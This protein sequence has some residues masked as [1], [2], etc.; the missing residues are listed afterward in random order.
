ND[1]LKGFRRY[2]VLGQPPAVESEAGGEYRAG[3]VSADV[4]APSVPTELPNM[5]IKP[6]ESILRVIGL[7]RIME[8]LARQ[9]I[10]GDRRDDPVSC[11]RS[12]DEAVLRS[13]ALLE[14]AT[15]QEQEDW[16]AGVHL[17]R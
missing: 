15:V 14:A 11:E 6:D 5:L 17:V 4:E 7:R 10:A 8:A 3:G 1:T 16:R 9:P 2:I 13:I 12:R